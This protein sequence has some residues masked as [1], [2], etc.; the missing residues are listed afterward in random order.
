[1]TTSAIT[2]I[3]AENASRFAGTKPYRIH[4]YEAG[5]GYPIVFLHGSG[6]GATGWSNFSPN[7]AEIAKTN[8]VYAVDMPGWGESD[9]P[10]DEQG[11]DQTA[12]LIAFLDEL[13]IERAALVG[14]SMGGGI[15]LQTAISHPER[16]SHL[17]TMGSPAPGANIFAAGDGPTEGLKVL[18][19]A[20]KDPSPQMMKA[21][22]Q[23]FCFNKAMA[24]DELA[25][26]RS[27]A[28]NA[29]PEHLDSWNH[30]FSKPLDE[31]DLFSAFY[32][33]TPRDLRKISAPTLL[34]HGRDDRVVP[35]EQSL[36]NLSAIPN[37]RLLLINGCGHWAQIEH[38]AEFNR[39]VVDFI[40]NN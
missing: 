14:N 31:N 21:L 40:A 13:G 34:V 18:L 22:V 9:T 17:I 29:H 6:P 15:S 11:R 8:H 5:E 25:D 32:A 27:A 36:R 28:A 7:I 35:F 20:Y 16:V 30:V 3:T 12:Q 37:S 39:V 19:A 4:Y 38:A 1:M 2:E 24:T 33:L 23:I 26:L 10:T